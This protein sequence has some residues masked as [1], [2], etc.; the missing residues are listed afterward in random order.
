[1]SLYPIRFGRAPDSVRRSPSL[2]LNRRDRLFARMS[3]PETSIFISYAWKDGADLAQRLQRDLAA[4]QRFDAWLDRRRLAGGATWTKEIERAIDNCQVLLALMTPGSYASEICRAEQ[5]RSLRKG[6]RVIPLLVQSGTDIPL[7]LEAKQYRDFTAARSY[8]SH[9]KLLLEDIGAGSGV[10]LKDQYRTTHV[11]YVTAPPTVMNFVERSEALAALRDA[12]FADHNRQPLAVTALAGM[13]GIGK[14]VL[15][16]ALTRDGVVQDAFPDGVVWITVGREQ[17]S[18]LVTTFREVGKALGDDLQRYDTLPACINQYKTALAQKA[19]LIV[20]DDIWRKSDLEPFLAESKRSRLLFTTRDAA[21]ARFIGAREHTAELLGLEQARELLAAW[22]DLDGKPRPAQLDAVIRECGGLPLALSIV[23]AML[24][25]ATPEEW[26]D[27]LEL[28]RKADLSGVAGRLP[29]G[30]ESFFR[31]VEVSVAALALEMQERYKAL[32]VLLEGMAAPLVILQTLWGVSEPEARRISRHFAD[33]SLTQRDT[34]GSSV[35]LHDLQLDYVRAQHSNQEAL[36]LIRGAVRLSFH[37]IERDPRQ[38]ASQMV[39]RLLPLKEVA[40]AR[41]TQAMIEAAPRPWLRPVR[42]S[43]HP[44]GADLVRMLTGHTGVTPSVAFVPGCARAVSASYDRTLRIWDIEA[45]KLVFTLVG[46]R[47]EVNAVAVT[48]DGRMGISASYDKTLKIWDLSDG[49]ELYTFA[50]HLDTVRSVAVAPDGVTAISGCADGSI[51]FWD[52]AGGVEKG[53][54]KAHDGLVSAVAVLP[55]GRRMVSASTDGSITVWDLSSR[56]KLLA[57]AGHTAAVRAIAVSPNGDRLA[58]ASADHTIKIWDMR[59]GMQLRILT[60]HTGDVSAVAIT[61]NGRCVLSA[62]WDKTLKLWDLDSGAVLQTLKGPCA[63]LGIAIAPDTSRVI[64]SCLDGTLNIWSLDPG[65]GS[66]GLQRD[67]G[68]AI[69]ADLAM[70]SDGSVVVSALSDGTLGILGPACSVKPRRLSGHKAGVMAVAVSAN[71][72]RA[73]SGSLDGSVLLWDLAAG[74]LLETL[75]HLDKIAF[76]AV[77]MTRDGSRAIAAGD[78][79][80]VWNVDTGMASLLWTANRYPSAVSRLAV[81]SDGVHLVASY[82]NGELALWDLESGTRLR[83]LRAAAS[84]SQAM[85]LVGDRIACVGSADASLHL[86]DLQRGL[87]VRRMQGHTDDIRSVHA[88]PDGRR[89]VSGSAD[90]TVRAWDAESGQLLAI[91]TADARVSTCSVTPDGRTI[92]AGDES[93]RVHFLELEL[94]ASPK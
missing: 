28:L 1:M 44:P 61:S 78:T 19:A 67:Y 77:A 68:D 88:T 58:S 25:G 33:R 43:L 92:V 21:I 79:I 85:C 45:E 72:N 12:L 6:K 82:F 62:S 75:I 18:D 60:G 42:P 30:Q 71:G 84:P 17:T 32:A 65:N 59:T 22:A 86:W 10:A 89:L 2:Q 49:R 34:D 46:H 87:G 81:T 24:R 14:T 23:G 47:A 91:F 41:F 63:A 93:G 35:R 66:F 54:I 16:H 27:T 69:T 8:A 20:V 74:R 15:A 64:S 3:R 38:F 7:H 90:K 48:P 40:V 9:F 29:P 51:G 70:T 83:C 36:D 13:G 26:D 94:A 53:M 4:E 57:L 73:V 50:G 80:R 11:T 56:G 39:G 52:L 55:D 5:L 31:A 76:G 37:V